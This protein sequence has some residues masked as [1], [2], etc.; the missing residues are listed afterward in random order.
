MTDGEN[1]TLS[2]AAMSTQGFGGVLDAL[3][4]KLESWLQGFGLVSP[5]TSKDLSETIILAP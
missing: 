3:T 5:Q 1:K 4:E 2:S